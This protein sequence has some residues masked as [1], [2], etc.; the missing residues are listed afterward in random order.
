MLFDLFTAWTRCVEVLLCVAL[1]LRL[2]MLAAFD[3]VAQAMQPYG[4]LGAVHA[5][6]KLLGLEQ[7]AFLERA[8]LAVLAFGDIEDDG[9]GVKLRRSITVHRTGGV[10]FEGGRDELAGRLRCV[11]VA[12][13]RLRVT[14]QFSKSDADTLTVRFPD[15]VIAS[16]KGGKRNGLR[17]GECGIPSRAVFRAGDLLAVLVFVGFGRLMFD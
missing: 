9:M 8:C 2:T 5:G 6:C 14:L 11:D 17:C 12:D 15:T 13:T 10:M 3:L 4:K 1:D 16:Y 7:A